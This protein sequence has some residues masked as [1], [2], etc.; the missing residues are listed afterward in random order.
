MFHSPLLYQNKFS[1]CEVFFQY[2]ISYH[3]SFGGYQFLF[4]RNLSVNIT[5]QA[6]V[7]GAIITD[8]S[9][10]DQLIPPKMSCGNKFILWTTFKVKKIRRTTKVLPRSTPFSLLTFWNITRLKEGCSL[11]LLH[12]PR[13]VMPEAHGFEPISS[14]DF[15]AL[16]ECKQMKQARRRLKLI[17]PIINSK[18]ILELGVSNLLPCKC[19]RVY[20]EA[21][22]VIG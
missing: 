13:D 15:P 9:Q 11:A 20:N 12:V 1:I 3:T 4:T 8:R 14:L 2:T 19:I 18:K 22:T 5:N 21:A 16:F 10:V 7:R 17:P 6:L